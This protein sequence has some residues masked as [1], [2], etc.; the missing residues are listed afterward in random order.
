MYSLGWDTRPF[1]GKKLVPGDQRG[2][3]E[4]SSGTRPKVKAE[5][6][7]RGKLA[8]ITLETGG[9]ALVPVEELCQIARRFNLILKGY[10]CEEEGEH[11][12]TSVETEKI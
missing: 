8:S 7:L 1:P 2:P 12:R 9:R 5:V 10:E 4:K 11:P 6:T 3:R